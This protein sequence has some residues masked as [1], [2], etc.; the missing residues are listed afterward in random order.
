[1]KKLPT[2]KTSFPA[3]VSH[4]TR[5]EARSGKTVAFAG[6]GIKPQGFTN[7]TRGSK[8]LLEVSSFFVVGCLGHQFK[9]RLQDVKIIRLIVP[10]HNFK[11]EQLF[12]LHFNFRNFELN[13]FLTAIH[14]LLIIRNQ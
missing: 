8:V 13:F 2:V 6:S 10:Q 5:R 4:A 3:F 12:Y 7:S 14:A 9:K 11:S 1:M